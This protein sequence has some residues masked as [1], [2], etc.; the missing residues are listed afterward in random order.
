MLIGGLLVA[1]SLY[2]INKKRFHNKE[3]IKNEKPISEL[4]VKIKI[5]ESNNNLEILK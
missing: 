5:I 4:I 1:S 3:L 2:F